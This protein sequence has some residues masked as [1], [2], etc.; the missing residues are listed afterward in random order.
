MILL[1]ISLLRKVFSARDGHMPIGK[2][3]LLPELGVLPSPKND[4]IATDYPRIALR[5][6]AP[7]VAYQLTEDAADVVLARKES[8]IVLQDLTSSQ[9]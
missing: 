4:G 1:I 8:Y 2:P 3:S 9:L 7:Y 5:L 6:L